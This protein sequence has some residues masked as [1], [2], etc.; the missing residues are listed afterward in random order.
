[1][2]AT[3]PVTFHGHFFNLRDPRCASRTEFRLLDLV[4]MTLCATIAGADDWPQVATFARAR[5]RGPALLFK[6][7][8]Q[9][10]F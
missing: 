1:M 3:L 10:A 8:V 7:F 2:T 4:F 9:Q 5:N 6:F